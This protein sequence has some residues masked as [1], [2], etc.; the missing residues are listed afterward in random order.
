[1]LFHA[2]NA[3]F[4]YDIVDIFVAASQANK[5]KCPG[6][7]AVENNFTPIIVFVVHYIFIA[8]TML[9]VGTI[10]SD[11]LQRPHDYL[12]KMPWHKYAPG[13]PMFIAQQASCLAFLWPQ[14]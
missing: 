6:R 11:L 9:I 8:L 7:V 4:I 12:I 13:Q 10:L 5:A 2:L 14:S 1:V 3:E